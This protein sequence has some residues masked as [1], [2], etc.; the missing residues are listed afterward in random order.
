MYSV[1][2]NYFE[3]IDTSEKSYWF[4]FIAGD[5]CIFGKYR[6]QIELANV[7]YNHLVK[8]KNAVEFDGP[9]LTNGDNFSRLVIYRKQFVK[10]L[11]SKGLIPHK[12][13]RLSEDI[14][15]L[16]FKRDFVRGLFDADGCIG[17]HTSEQK[18]FIATFSIAG[19][20]S[21]MY[22]ISDILSE[23]TNTKKEPIKDT[24]ADVFSISYGGRWNVE[25]IG[26]YLWN[27][28]S[29]HLDRKYD[30][31]K[32]IEEY[33]SENGFRSCP[34]SFKHYTK[35]GR[36]L[37]E[38]ICCVC[39]TTFLTRADHANRPNCGRFCK[40]CRKYSGKGSRYNAS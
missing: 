10:H 8:F 28:S 7:D 14:I 2:E 3:N 29:V 32:K 37:I 39:R 11:I 38:R 26:N 36:G 12:S 18:R 9:I 17:I 34:R 22:G 33:N 20:L 40:D 30:I 15:P 27:D 24:R 5:G 13:K 25:K 31:F 4:G 19:T 23:I 1:N 35:D 16:Q 21:L 6:C